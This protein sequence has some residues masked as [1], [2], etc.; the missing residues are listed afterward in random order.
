MKN[1]ETLHKVAMEASDGLF[2]WHLFGVINAISESSLTDS[3]PNLEAEAR[4]YLSVY[5]PE[6]LEQHEAEA[7]HAN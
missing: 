7:T 5:H 3:C 4:D 2:A 1:N 6:I